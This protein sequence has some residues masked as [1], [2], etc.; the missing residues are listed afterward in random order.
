MQPDKNS[1]EQ[2][3]SGSEYDSSLESAPPQETSVVRL[4]GVSRADER[5]HRR[6][7]IF[8]ELLAVVVI[9]IIGVA[10]MIMASPHTPK[11]SNNAKKSPANDFSVKSLPLQGV[12]GNEQ[13]QVGQADRLD[14]N[15]QLSINNTLVLSPTAAPSSPVT[16]Q[17]YYDKTSN[18]PYYYNGT[19]F[20]SMSQ[21]AVPEHITSLGGAAGVI[22]LGDGLTINGNQLAIS[23]S[24]LQAVTNAGLNAAGVKSL[25]GLTGDVTLTAGPGIAISGTTISNNG[26]ISL[27]SGSG[28][29]TI[30]NN[31]S[32][33]YTITENSGPTGVALGPSSAQVDSSNNPSVFINKT[34]SGSL[35]DLQ[36]NGV[37]KFV[38]DQNGAIT[39]GT[40]GFSQVQ[41]VPAIVNTI[42]S[43]SGAITV[44]TGL[45]ESGNTLSNSGVTGI[46][47][48]A[49]Q[50]IASASTGS[51]TLSLPQ[52]VDTDSNVQFGSLSVGSGN[53]TARGLVLNDG[54]SHTTTLQ[55]L[56]PGSQNQVITIPATNQVS[57][58]DTV[59][60]QLLSNCSSGFSGGGTLNTLVKFT[61]A[62]SL[63]NSGL[64]D[65]GT[66]VTIGGEGLIVNTVTASTLQSNSTLNITPGSDLTIGATNQLFLLQGNASST[67]SISANGHKTVISFTPPTSADIAIAFPNASGTVCLQNSVSCGFASSGSGVT[68]LNTSTGVLTL[69]NASTGGGSTITINNALADG[70][71]KGIATFNASNFQGAGGVINTIQ[72]IGTASNVQFG[73]LGVGIAG[74]G[75]SGDLNLAPAGTLFTDTIKTTATGSGNL[76]VSSDGAGSNITFLINGGNDS[77]LFP[78]GGGMGQTICTTAITCASG[79]GQA[80]ILEPGGVQ[81]A[82]AN[83]TAIFVNKASGSGNLIELQAAGSDAFAIDNTGNTTIKGGGVTNGFN[84]GGTLGVNTITPSGLLTIGATGQQFTLQ[85]NGSSAISATGGGFLTNVGFNIGSGGTAPTG[86][87]TYQFEND[88][89]VTPGTYN[90]CTTAGN[91]VGVG[92]SITG[93]G[94]SGHLALFTGSSNIGN[95]I[96][97]DNGSGT[98]TVG[99]NLAVG[100]SGASQLSIG[101]ASSANGTLVFNNSSNGNAVTIQEAAAPS[102]PVTLK[103][104]NQSG[105][106]AVSASGPLSLDATTGALSCATCLTGG[107]P[108]GGVTS[109]NTS[110]GALTLANASTGGGSTITI[111]D[112]QADGTTKGIATFNNSNFQASGG[113]VNTIQDIGTAATPTFGTLTLQGAGGLTVGT[114]AV[115]G[116]T[117]QI[118]FR[119][120]TTD[121]GSNFT[122]TLKVATLTG[123]KVL[124]IPNIP[125]ATGTFIVGVGGSN[126]SVDSSGGIVSLSNAPNFS[127]SVTAVGVNAG[128]GLLQGSLG[129]TVTGGV[130][131]LNAS[132]NFATNINTG[133]STGAVNIGNSSAASIGLASSGALTVAASNF[134]LSGSGLTVGV[135][136]TQAGLTLT[137]GTASRSVIIQGLAPSSAGNGTIQIPS[138]PGSSTDTVCLLTLNN[139]SGGS[140][141]T[142]V[143]TAGGTSNY[144]SKFTAGSAIGNSIL[145]DNGTGVTLSTTANT[146]PA[147]LF[148][149][150]AS[151]QFQVSSAGAVT[152][153][154]VNSGTGLIQGTGGLTVSGAIASVNASS[155]FATNI[156]TGSS[157]GA[158]NIGNGSAGAIGLQSASTLTV[159]TTN[160]NLSSGTLTVGT[161]GSQANLALTTATAGNS[162]IIQGLAPSGTGSAT[163]QIPTI[164]GATSDI[165]CLQTLNNCSGGSGSSGVTTTG[166]TL[167]F[168]SKFS[169]GSAIVNSMLFDNGVG[170]SVGNTAV[171]G[172]FNVGASNQFQVS[173]AG[174]VTAVGVNSGT[175][176][177]QGTGGLTA[178]GAAISLNASSNF[179]T[180]INTGTS[181]GAI[182]IGNSSAASIGLASSG[183]LTVTTSNFSLSGSGLSVGVSGAQANLTLTTATASRSVIVQALAPSSAGNGT[184]QIPSI[185]G[186]STDTVCLLTLNNCNGGGG[187]SGVTTV[188]GTANFVT[189][190]SGG[191]T[192]VNSML[193]DNGVGV[194]VGNTAIG[195]LFNVGASNQFQVSSAGAVTAVGVNSGTGL[196]QGTGGLTLTGAVSINTS[197]S[198]VTNINT[199]GGTGAINIGNSSAASIGLASS[200]A[201][202]V[203]TSNFNLSGSSLTVGVSGV[204]S[205][206]VLTTATASRSVILQGLAPSSAGNGT[207]QI[208]S[209]PGSSTDTVCLFTLANCAGTGGGVTTT[210]TGVGNLG[211]IPVFTNTTGTTIGASNIFQVGSGGTAQISI[212][213]TTT[214]AQ[215]NV[216]SLN[217]FQVTAIGA[218][219]TSGGLTVT[220]GANI[221]TTTA[222]VT[223]INTSSGAIVNIKSVTG[224]GAINIGNITATNTGT[225]NINIQN[226]GSFNINSQALAGGITVNGGIN[227]GT[228]NGYMGVIQ[229]GQQGGNAVPTLD[230]YASNI[231]IGAGGNGSSNSASNIQIGVIA[232][233][234]ATQIVGIGTDNNNSHVTIQG[235]SNTTG[236]ALVAGDA[237]NAGTAS[238]NGMIVNVGN[239]FTGD[240]VNIGST[241]GNDSTVYIAP[242][243]GNQVVNIATNAPASLKTSAV[244]IGSSSASST[245]ALQG[246]GGISLGSA[247]GAVT[248]GATTGT[249]TL[250]LGQS[251]ASQTINIGTGSLTGSNTTTIN[252]GTGATVG[253]AG[254][255]GC[256]DVVN[257]GS[258]NGAAGV[259]N[260]QA[261]AGL[262]IKTGNSGVLT[263][264]T[265]GG[266]SAVSINSGT[267]GITLG[268]A[269]GGTNQGVLVKPISNTTVAFQIQPAS[270]ATPLF[271]VDST[272][273]NVSILTNNAAE[274]QAWQTANNLTAVRRKHSTVIANGYIYALGGVNASNVDQSTV[275]DAKLNA[276]G[277]TGTWANMSSG[278]PAIRSTGAAV[279]LN[280]YMYYL[281]GSNTDTVFFAKLNAN[282]GTTGT[283]Q[284]EGTA[285]PCGSASPINNNSINGGTGLSNLSAFAANGYLYVVAS[286][287][288]N[289]ITYHAK[290]YADGTT[291]AWTT[292]ASTITGVVNLAGLTVANGY[293]YLIGGEDSGT[294]PRSTTFYTKINTDGTLGTWTSGSTL[295][296]PT[297][298]TTAVSANGYLY[299]IGGV[300]TGGSALKNVYYAQVSSSGSIGSWTTST[301]VLPNASGVFWGSAAASNG[302]IYLTGGASGSAGSPT[303][304]QS[305]YYA[306]LSRISV[307]GSLD[308][309]GTSGQD[310]SGNGGQG[311]SLTAGN[312]IIAGTLNVSGAAS[313]IQG[314]SV[315]GDAQFNGSALFQNTA[316][317]V[318][319]FQ[320]QNSSGAGV[321]N[322]DTAN[323][324]VGINDSAPSYSLSFGSG[325]DRTV[326]VET[327][328]AANTNGNQLILLAGG[329]NGSGD[330][331]H[332]VIQGGANGSTGGSDG[333]GVIINGS[334]GATVGSGGS[335][336]AIQLTAG[337]SGGSSSTRNGGNI[338]LTAGSA[339][340][341]GGINGSVI[342]QNAA[343]AANSFQVLS[344]VASGGTVAVAISTN[345]VTTGANAA[346]AIL[347]VAKDSGTSRSINA[348][349]TINASGTDYAEYI[350]WSGLHPDQGSIVSYQGSEYVVSA[351]TQAGF[352]GGGDLDEANSLLVAFAGQV[353]VKVTG[354]VNVGDL[355]VDNGDGTVKAVTPAQATIGELFGKI[356]IA[357]QASSDPGVK[358]VQAAIGTTSSNA[359]DLQAQ[360]GNFTD[361]NVTGVT[362][363]SQ[364]TV[365]GPATLASLTV[366]G[367]AQF[368]GNIIV[369]GH[370]ITAGGEPT[371]D[372]QTAGGAG[373]AVS[374]SGNDTTGTISIT[375][376]SNPTAGALSEVLFSKVYGAAPH[377][378]LSP[379]NNNAAGLRFYKGDT[380]ASNFMFNA[381]DAP[382]ANTTYNFDYFVAQ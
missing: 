224:G 162:V 188:G 324:R 126:L 265:T 212:G 59:C 357:Q 30:T 19:Q 185:P 275:M 176:L 108:G 93:S 175:G 279:T 305:V 55:G 206:L 158:V 315:G 29:L 79:G 85:G 156:N 151:N 293:A 191:S 159:A 7:I 232:A 148:N 311:G 314:I 327:Q 351:P 54:S 336:G 6:R 198:G 333:G 114:S 328:S 267:S 91:C 23:G 51:I 202:T 61:G 194:S 233:S 281:G 301:N 215:F 81:T 360:N 16:G 297:D 255:G 75:T 80:V 259:T 235:G 149:V 92:G 300:T 382:A 331:G 118:V 231:N 244:T 52:N 368:K 137:T 234:T 354:P 78:T 111:N 280:G 193:F 376:G 49:H 66:N 68:S 14:V 101:V 230:M 319:A 326:G 157:T 183:A 153:V 60:L 187:V 238:L 339:V 298:A 337:N 353:A 214:V 122:S 208:P 117:G 12:K 362:N 9:S 246:G 373:A 377:V 227:I 325:A 136:G 302:Y 249:S 345:N 57:G 307:A 317:S 106:F 20:I 25:Q 15:G 199:G 94:T 272:N 179:A 152:A 284:C 294:T 146:T 116:N 363:L 225:G 28:N 371:A 37:N 205:S 258:L 141:G 228:S 184:I 308:L 168:I 144:I 289:T 13:L 161:S 5:R 38:V 260:V 72:N 102:S 143:T 150:G 288:T 166:G 70:A 165:V 97:Q 349:G 250:T 364:L 189:K 128:A 216:G 257:I 155:N 26:V 350:P 180:N 195:G 105:T 124:T 129:L 135:S 34:G 262:N 290:A 271:S 323:S 359:S 276:N 56:S 322:V 306:S 266:S 241:S 27:A 74:T 378:V 264:G 1:L 277:S 223:N 283:W 304:L 282:D 2:N 172:L 242:G 95:S 112:A 4:P 62:S 236:L 45:S 334:N 338:T 210:A 380:T 347:V 219:T 220:G 41:G 268:P 125:G 285:T 39:S 163:I 310:Q 53:L 278:L 24:L 18:Q 348:A 269:G 253:C 292:T 31:G 69:A 107:G 86:S 201:L 299:L 197:G 263:I 370:I 32:G 361:L 291:G 58:V 177:I 344:T 200:G 237:T 130:V 138:I 303:V 204:Q 115:S 174:A 50:L 341:S 207:V 11:L 295:V 379:S 44:G 321:L 47:G 64:V 63:G 17:V 274:T 145:Y 65:D 110:V 36:S 367:D 67:L 335:G 82:S 226:Q 203:A 372:A 229:I 119:D 134:N 239:G 247:G 100:T 332:V 46:T 218:V 22:G 209:I 273:S 139:C 171:G 178:S 71:T 181:T 186:S 73:S 245:V 365:A 330:G 120:G 167:N 127:G 154:G 170:V 296:V 374:V 99:G 48:T 123:N 270:T 221:N 76:S 140:G 381:L 261:S 318:N 169:A 366:T 320:V 182:N 251:T 254:L 142:G 42:G 343:N 113:V 98:V 132:S 192:V 222:D 213:S 352:V 133:T 356:G 164:P 160:L 8:A 10:A 109:L 196:I 329:A 256:Q 346:N 313:F 358:I 312:T 342:V 243:T 87:V 173:S 316:N 83:K 84:V 21:A 89:T 3:F 77:F 104:P 121:G 309:I 35:L 369:G 211:Y 252:I 217:Q 286:N 287:G 43:D 375:T 90:V 190:F 40:I 33:G 96:V 240:T 131:S 103:L 340:I 248:I 88:N 147:G 355:L